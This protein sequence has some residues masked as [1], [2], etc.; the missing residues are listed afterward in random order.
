M[1]ILQKCDFKAVESFHSVA[2][3]SAV[4]MNRHEIEA[5]ETAGSVLIM[6]R[7]PRTIKAV[8]FRTFSL[9]LAL[10]FSFVASTPAS[11]HGADSHWMR[12]LGAKEPLIWGRKDGILFGLPSEGGLPAPWLN[13]SRGDFSC[14]RTAA[15]S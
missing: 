5:T 11:V 13:S 12:P 9:W 7:R 10:I 14:N 2:E 1:Q 8:P 15:T 6:F 4:A 3:W